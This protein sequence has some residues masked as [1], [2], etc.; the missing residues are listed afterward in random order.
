[1]RT[2]YVR[3]RRRVDLVDAISHRSPTGDTLLGDFP[4]GFS[5][6]ARLTSKATE[7]KCHWH[8]P[9]VQ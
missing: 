3:Q 5:L 4:V 8:G 7:G 6:M 2:R 9:I 1:M